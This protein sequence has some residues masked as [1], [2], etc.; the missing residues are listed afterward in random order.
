M[1][2]RRRF[3]IIVLAV[4]LL[5]CAH[6]RFGFPLRAIV[7]HSPCL[8]ASLATAATLSY[9]VFFPTERE[10]RRR[11]NLNCKSAIVID[12]MTKEVL[13]DRN[14]GGTRSIASLTKLMTALTLIDMDFDWSRVI[15]ITREDARNSAKSRL[16]VGEKFHASDLFYI[17]LI[18]SDNRAARALARSTELSKEEFAELMNEKARSLGLFETKFAD[19]TGLDARNV[20]T[21]KECAMLLNAALNQKLISNA[22]TTTR[23]S[24]RSTNHKRLRNIV[25]TN[26]LLRSKWKV[27]GGK[28]GYIQKSGYC[29]A[30][31]LTDSNG[32]DIT[33]VVLGAP[34]SGTRFSVA[35]SIVTWTFKNMDRLDRE[36]HLAT[37]E[38]TRNPTD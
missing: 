15:A 3:I 29:L 2:Q 9:E 23:Y 17:M 5:L 13:L 21:A 14:S 8:N 35:R 33:V 37:K 26:R 22:V 31:R 30:T 10:M 16:K 19:P 18:S 12:N 27:K 1:R 34:W 7:E 38:E 6:Y 20:S 25:N 32:H 24:Y 28:T 11:P 36:D 4:V